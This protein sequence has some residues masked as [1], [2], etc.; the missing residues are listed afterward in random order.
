[1]IDMGRGRDVKQVNEAMIS[2]TQSIFCLILPG[3]SPV[4]KRFFDVMRKGCIPLMPTWESFVPGKRSGWKKWDMSRPP[5]AVTYPF[6]NIHFFGQKED[7]KEIGINYERDLIVTFD[8]E[9]GA[10]CAR[11][12]MEEIMANSTEM[13][14]LQSNVR[15]YAPLFAYGLED[16]AYRYVDGFS[17]LL[18]NIRH[19]VKTYDM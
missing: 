8:G 7:N 2:Y 17:A 11:K 16:N 12:V 9:C 5:I 1:M 15:K 19:F 3:D 18:V 14:R 13:R 4:Q 6:S 10:R